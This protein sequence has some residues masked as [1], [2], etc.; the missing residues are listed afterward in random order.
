M[1]GKRDWI[2]YSSSEKGLY[3]VW[4]ALVVRL[5]SR[6]TSRSSSGVVHF[7][8]AA[9]HLSVYWHMLVPM[10]APSVTVNIAYI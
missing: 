6:V 8:E 1:Q 2:K 3:S 4:F 10:R 9:S 7:V 5:T